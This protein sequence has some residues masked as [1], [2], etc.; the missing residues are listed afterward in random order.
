M[1]G[2]DHAAPHLFGVSCFKQAIA[3]PRTTAQP[4]SPPAGAPQLASGVGPYRGND[5][6]ACAKEHLCTHA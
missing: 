3:H 4:L 5:P 6:I 2:L 1:P